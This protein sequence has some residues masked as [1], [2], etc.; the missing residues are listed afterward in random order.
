MINK[1][2]IVYCNEEETLLSKGLKYNLSYKQNKWL[3]TL[4][5]EGE[6]AISQLPIAEQGYMRYQVANNINQLYKQYDINKNCNTH[7]DK[8]EREYKTKVKK[9]L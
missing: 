1:T 6:T 5:L 7:L 3:K 9:N 4:A 8:K 2:N